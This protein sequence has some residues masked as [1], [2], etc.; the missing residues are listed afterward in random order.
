MQWIL[1]KKGNKIVLKSDCMITKKIKSDRCRSLQVLWLYMCACVFVIHFSLINL[2]FVFGKTNKS[3]EKGGIKNPSIHICKTMSR[4]SF[5]I[6]GSRQMHSDASL[7]LPLYYL[8]P[9][10]SVSFCLSL[11]PRPPPHAALL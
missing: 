2:E 6:G 10:S 11:A 4:D 7:R 3:T 8:S 1:Y 9:S 5:L